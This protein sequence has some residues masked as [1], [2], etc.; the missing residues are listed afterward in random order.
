MPKGVD[1]Q[2]QSYLEQMFHLPVDLEPLLEQSALTVYALT[3]NMHPK[4]ARAT[5]H[6][7]F[8]HERS[9]GLLWH[10]TFAQW[11]HKGNQTK[12]PT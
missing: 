10:T 1:Q 4:D 9:K 7:Q 11:I 3:A 2:T 8:T 5:L 6:E 12:D